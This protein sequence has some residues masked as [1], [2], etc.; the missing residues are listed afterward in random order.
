MSINNTYPK[1]PVSLDLK[2]LTSGKGDYNIT[3]QNL[4]EF[5]SSNSGQSL[6]TN[7]NEG[8]Y[9]V[10]RGGQWVAEAFVGLP[11]QGIN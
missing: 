9:L 6:P 10:F 8:D 11:K 5:I 4:I 7:A 3:V 1:I 2:I